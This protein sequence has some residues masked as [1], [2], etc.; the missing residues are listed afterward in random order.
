MRSRATLLSAGCAVLLC[1]AV[2]VA[3]AISARAHTH[4][5]TIDLSPQHCNMLPRTHPRAL[6][7]IINEIFRTQRGLEQ[8]ENYHEFCRLLS[9]L[10][11]SPKLTPFHLRATSFC[12]LKTNFQLSE[13]VAD[14]GYE[15]CISTIAGF[16]I[17]SFGAWKWAGNSVHYLLS[18]WDRLISSIPYIKSERPHMLET[19][20]PGIT[21]AYIRSRIE[22]VEVCNNPG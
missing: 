6:R 22:S 10:R 4:T 3:H 16:T 5:H 14:D 7:R 11:I 9:R 17:E 12:E 20:S 1:M 2:K 8:Q 13:L 19:H 21:E 15:E 18:L